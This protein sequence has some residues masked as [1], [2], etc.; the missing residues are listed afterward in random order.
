M[1]LRCGVTTAHQVFFFSFLLFF[2]FS[3]RDSL[4]FHF[5]TPP[6]VSKEVEHFDHGTGIVRIG[7]HSELVKEIIM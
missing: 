4:Y 6:P 3:R 7:C 1:F 5:Y 2:F